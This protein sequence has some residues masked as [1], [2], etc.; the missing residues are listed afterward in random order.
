MLKWFM[1][2]FAPKAPPPAVPEGVYRFEHKG[3]VKPKTRD[4]LF[5]APQ[6][7]DIQRPA[8][9]A[10]NYRWIEYKNNTFDPKLI[11]PS[12][13]DSV[14]SEKRPD[15]P[16]P[17][18]Q[19]DYWHPSD[20]SATGSSVSGALVRCLYVTGRAFTHTCSTMS[21]WWRGQ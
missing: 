4:T 7:V 9:E 13:S 18:G 14:C 1:A 6:P 17:S 20:V 11:K 3:T 19:I 8:N 5:P 10:D 21:G 2:L 15:I 16:D 12:V